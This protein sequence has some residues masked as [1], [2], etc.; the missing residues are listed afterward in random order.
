MNQSDLE[1][2][3]AAK[4]GLLAFVNKNGVIIYKKTEVS[5]Y[6]HH[7]GRLVSRPIKAKEAQAIAPSI[8]KYAP[9]RNKF[10]EL[11]VIHKSDFAEGMVESGYYYEW[12]INIINGTTTHKY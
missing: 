10:K 11:Y 4:E 12:Q 7:K 6:E 9:C 5:K 8:L 3:Q 2:A 1:I